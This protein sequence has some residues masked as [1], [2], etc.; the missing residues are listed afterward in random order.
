MD[1]RAPRWLQN[2]DASWQAASRRREANEIRSWRNA[3]T[4]GARGETA[5]AVGMASKTGLHPP[6]PGDRL[7]DLGVASAVRASAVAMRARAP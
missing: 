1:L 4:R 5:L 7:E 3:H 2:G 6:G